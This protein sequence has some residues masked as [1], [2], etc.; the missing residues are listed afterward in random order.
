MHASRAR[1]NQ[2]QA[3]RW[4]PTSSNPA[5]RDPIAFGCRRKRRAGFGRCKPRGR[6]RRLSSEPVNTALE[7]GPCNK[8]RLERQRNMSCTMASSMGS[9]KNQPR[10]DG[11]SCYHQVHSRL[12]GTTARIDDA[13]TSN[14]VAHDAPEGSPKSP[15]ENPALSPLTNN[16]PTDPALPPS[17]S[18]AGPSLTASQATPTTLPDPR[19]PRAADIQ[20]LLSTASSSPRQEGRQTPV[21]DTCWGSPGRESKPRGKRRL[22]ELEEPDLDDAA[23][24]KRA[25]REVG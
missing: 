9:S 23:C 22:H 1:E 12:C 3:S 7:S 5:A 15:V 11:R 16:S 19:S 21:A 13:K 17:P 10:R 2:R 20:P 4:R 6:K 18:D 25:R 8:R 14:G 24:A